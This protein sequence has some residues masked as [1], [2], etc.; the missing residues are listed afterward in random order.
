MV[1]FL[2]RYFQNLVKMFEAKMELYRRQIEELECH[3]L[4]NTPET[5]MSSQSK[6]YT[7]TYDVLYLLIRVVQ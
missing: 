7:Y 6:L 5:G 4:A 3:L 1:C 2:S